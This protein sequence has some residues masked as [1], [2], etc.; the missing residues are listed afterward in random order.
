MT[1]LNADVYN[2]WQTHLHLLGS[3]ES[4]ACILLTFSV[5]GSKRFLFISQ[6]LT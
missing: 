3:L 5:I 4:A 2:S 1:D 6:A